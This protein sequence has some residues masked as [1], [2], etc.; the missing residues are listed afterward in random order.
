MSSSIFL[1][2][3]MGEIKIILLGVQQHLATAVPDIA[4]L[5]KD[6][7]QLYMEQ[8]PVKW[9][10][11]LLDVEDIQFEQR[12]HGSEQARTRLTLTVA[13]M[14][15]TSSSSTAPNQEKA[16]QLIDL[17]EQIHDALQNFTT[18]EYAPLFRSSVKKILSDTGKEAY[19]L[20]YETAY[21]T[22]PPSEQRP[23]Y[24]KVKA[25]TIAQE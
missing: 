3:V 6:W 2:G 14:R 25:V 19:K 5:D 4:H 1:A 24:H 17:I 22:A 13:G 7:G 20:T 18:G 11:C 9:P 8:P 15:L 23:K 21:N 12:G 10:C 16:Y